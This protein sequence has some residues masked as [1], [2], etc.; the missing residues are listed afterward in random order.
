MIDHA[1]LEEWGW[2]HRD[3]QTIADAYTDFLV[4]L[5]CLGAALTALDEGNWYEFVNEFHYAHHARRGAR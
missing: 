5:V 4:S 1:A 3:N 2:F